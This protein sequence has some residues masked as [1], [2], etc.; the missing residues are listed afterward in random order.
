MRTHAT[1]HLI[2]DRTHQCDTT[3][4]RT[5]P[6]GTT[7]AY[8]LLDG[9]GSNDAVRDW[10]RTAA[11]R[12][13]RTAAVHGDAEAGLREVYTRYATDPDRE[14]AAA[15]VA[16]TTGRTLTIAWC[17]DSR[18]YLLTDGA[19]QRLT[20]DHNLRRVYPAGR[21]YPT[22]PGGNRN[23]ITSYLGN[24]ETDDEVKARYGHPAIEAAT[25]TLDGG[26]H[27]LLL[28][29]DGAYEP[30]EDAGRSLADYLAGDVRTAA[31]GIV[32]AAVATA[33]NHPDPHA[34]NATVLVADLPDSR[35]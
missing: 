22:A 4:T 30:L 34:D 28:A 7:R 5:A 16:V 10:V 19:L 29:S 14:H 32:T 33:H 27:R 12:L 20:D 6:N 18:A 35:H 11:R 21:G 31:T 26:K 17:G 13:A 2:G 1:A 8:V 9:I 23:V 24:Y 15:V 3:A 25:I